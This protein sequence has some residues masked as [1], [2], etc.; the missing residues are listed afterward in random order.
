MVEK[1]GSE[2][3][4]QGLILI[5][6]I[7]GFLG[8]QT[9]YQC[10]E[11]G[12]KVRGTVRSTKNEQKMKVIDKF[13]NR[14]NLEIVE[15]DLL[16]KESWPK[17]VDGCKYVLHVA[18]PFPLGIPKDENE[19]IKP[20]VEGTINILTAAKEGGIAHTVIVS[21]VAAIHSCG[22]DYKSYNT[23]DDWPE[24]NVK[25][26]PPYEKSKTLAEQAAWAFYDALDDTPT[27]MKI[28]AVNPGWILGP[29]LITT[30]FTSQELITLMLTNKIFGIPKLCW[31]IV[32]VRDVAN[33]LIRCLTRSDISKGRRYICTAGSLWLSDVANILRQE[34]APLGYKVT[35]R[36]V[37]I[38]N[39]KMAALFDKKV[40]LLLPYMGKYME[41]RN[42][43]IVH[44]LGIEFI[45]MKD[46]IIKM[47]YSLIEAGFVKTKQQEKDAKAK[48]KLDKKQKGKE[49]KPVVKE[50]KG[51]AKVKEEKNTIVEEK[52]GGMVEMEE[53]K[54]L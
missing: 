18:S 9:C 47:A 11:N 5:T 16:V 27:K 52:D 29:S 54:E 3:H 26:Y 37:A 51:E 35:K 21:S 28:S 36:N 13:P 17:A 30:D 40:K 46:A 42:E 39:A 4:L 23:E 6:G 50:V 1:E 2:P 38:C 34:F 20:A 7:T 48:Q 8:S 14:E 41:Y 53:T 49:E 12:Y 25:G 32:D 22:K 19:L 15:A 31:G 10:L 33:S 24:V 43:R 44:E 45:S